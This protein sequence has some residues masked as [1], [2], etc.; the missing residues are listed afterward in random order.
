MIVTAAQILASIPP[1]S[2]EPDREIATKRRSGGP[3]FK[4]VECQNPECRGE[5]EGG[6]IV[7]GLGQRCYRRY[8]WHKTGQ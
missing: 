8:R 4:H 3:K 2:E 1:G 6:K 5:P 7:K